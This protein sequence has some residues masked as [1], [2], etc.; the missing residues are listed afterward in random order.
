MNAPSPS[1][2]ANGNPASG[3]S[4]AALL[5]RLFDDVTALV[6]NEVQLA[7][8]EF[9][10]TANEVKTRALAMATGGALVAAGGLALVAALIL[11]L[12]TVMAP[13]LAAL[14]VGVALC[15]IGALLLS[16][17][18]KRLASGGFDRTKTSLERDAHVVARRT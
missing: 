9:V 12:A 18:R 13:W 11:A 14:I 1:T 6:R 3:V 5:G 15:A 17:A 10:T 2:H 16:S 4:M 8:A 7:K